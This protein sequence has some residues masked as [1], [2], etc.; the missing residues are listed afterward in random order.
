MIYFFLYI[1]VTNEI[2]DY[3]LSSTEFVNKNLIDG[4]ICIACEYAMQYIDKVIGNEKSREKIEKM[5][6][7][8][9]NHLPKSLSL[10]CN[11]FVDKY[12]DAVITILSEDV[13]PKEVC[14]MVDLCK[15]S[16]PHIKGTLTWKKNPII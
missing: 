2:P 8:V 14:V 16:V 12:A 1:S 4:G 5:V 6:H 9:C 11:Q 13:S 10:E 15:S 3:P 7:S